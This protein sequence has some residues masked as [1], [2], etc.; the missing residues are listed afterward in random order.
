MGQTSKSLII[1]ENR[2]KNLKEFC[3]TNS[4]KMGGVVEL[5]IDLYLKDYKSVQKLI[6]DNKS[7]SHAK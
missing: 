4:L 6:D 2:H 3:Q 1:D 7:S 5:L